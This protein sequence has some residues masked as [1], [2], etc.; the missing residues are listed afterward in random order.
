MNIQVVTLFPEPLKESLSYGVIGQA[1]RAGT[2]N[3][4]TLNPREF[5]TDNHHTVDDRVF[6]G[7][8]GMLMLAEPLAQ[9]IESLKASEKN[10]T[11]VVHL[12]PRGRKFTDALAREWAGDW[13]ANQRSLTLIATRYAGV[14]AR[15]LEEFCD[16][17]ISIGDF[18]VSGGDGPAALVIDAVLRHLPGVLGNE[19]SAGNDS[20]SNIIFES[21]QYTRPR[22]WRGRS[23][24]EVLLGGDPALIGDWQFL[25]A[26]HATLLRRPD[27]IR[28]QSD[29]FINQLSKRLS[30]ISSRL[31][32]ERRMRSGR[33]GEN[34]RTRAVENM[35]QQLKS[36]LALWLSRK[37]LG[38]SL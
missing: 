17:E 15:F 23:V 12:S 13:I 34:S 30:E 5:T 3:L 20:F 32:R 31:E 26:L 22:E 21:A 37:P 28:D 16:D 7:G 19:V 9:A 38:G 29:D 33:A 25:E 8:D 14:D 4:K 35:E 1:L 27:L 2:W 24:P 10:E 6:G 18:V 36:T 11:R